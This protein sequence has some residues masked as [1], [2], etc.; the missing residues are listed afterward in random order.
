MKM[1]HDFLHSLLIE[2]PEKAR[3][4]C[5]FAVQVGLHGYENR[6][7]ADHVPVFAMGESIGKEEGRRLGKVDH[8][9]HRSTSDPD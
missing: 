6:T 2:K 9:V 1:G 5:T 3:E 8:S 7:G 4:S